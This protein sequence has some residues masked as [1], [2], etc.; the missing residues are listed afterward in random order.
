[1]H[2]FTTPHRASGY[3]LQQSNVSYDPLK[4]RAVTDVPKIGEKFL[5]W[6]KKVS[7]V[8]KNRGW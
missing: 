1:M 5:Q 8:Q 4:S 3:D 6:N 2:S 7:R